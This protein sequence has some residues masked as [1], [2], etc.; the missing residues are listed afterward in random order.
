MS[1]R[2]KIPV[3]WYPNLLGGQ[4]GKQ[5]A[6]R[7]WKDDLKDPLPHFSTFYHVLTYEIDEATK[8]LHDF[9]SSPGKRPYI[10]II[11]GPPG[12]GKSYLAQQVAEKIDEL[13]EQ[14][15]SGRRLRPDDRV[16]FIEINLAQYQEPE[17]FLRSLRQRLSVKGRK[18]V[19]LDEFDVTAG[20]SSAVRYLIG[21]LWDAKI[22]VDHS[23]TPFDSTA[24]ILAGSYL[25]DRMT[26]RYISEAVEEVNLPLLLADLGIAKQDRDGI[27]FA[28]ELESS[29]IQLEVAQPN[30]RLSRIAHL[31]ALEKLP[32]LLSRV[33]GFEIE[34]LDLSDPL[35]VTPRSPLQL[36][37][38]DFRA[39]ATFDLVPKQHA[40]AILRYHTSK[41]A[42]P[43][44]QNHTNLPFVNWIECY[45]HSLL[46]E[47]LLRVYELVGRRWKEHKYIEVGLLHFL[48]VVP[49]RYGMR[50]LEFVVD[51]ID[52]PKRDKKPDPETPLAQFSEDR[53]QN[54][55]RHVLWNL[56][57]NSVD[58]L[59]VETV[60]PF[61]GEKHWWPQK[62]SKILLTN[63]SAG[64]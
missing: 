50:S 28:S 3:P 2:K 9:F 49:L 15:N 40:E 4:E 27:Q 57:K 51:A 21:P 47:R 56:H 32:D 53:I 23:S 16:R 64:I 29:R 59:W 22:D 63:S 30:S 12:S 5:G 41:K 6:L 34:L 48:T 46:C 37:F 36:C 13:E 42:N 33:N 58:Q 38:C 26:Y 11:L 55:K 61:V 19:I 35:S 7:K 44:L 60:H 8:Q 24:F 31:A 43:E 1:E 10:G 17:Q 54:I 62:H 52:A 18:L 39:A 14:K 20:M 45:K 25:S